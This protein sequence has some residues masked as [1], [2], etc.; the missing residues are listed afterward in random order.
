MFFRDPIDYG[1]PSERTLVMTPTPHLLC[2]QLTDALPPR[3]AQDVRENVPSGTWAFSIGAVPGLLRVC[4]T[5]LP[6]VI[7]SKL[8]LGTCR[9]YLETTRI[10]FWEP[11]GTDS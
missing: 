5:S 7:G 1:A 6:R 4:T 8:H 3:M 2:Y 9:K 10:Q 11:L